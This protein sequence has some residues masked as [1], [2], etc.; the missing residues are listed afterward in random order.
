MR[1][2]KIGTVGVKP[3]TFRALAPSTAG[4]K[5]QVTVI[6]AE[7]PDISYIEDFASN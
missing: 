3:L 4:I 6:N 1:A 7:L 2:G 5:Y